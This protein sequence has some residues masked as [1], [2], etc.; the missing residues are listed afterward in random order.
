M[1]TG[2]T[3][4]IFELSFSSRY[5]P[6]ELFFPNLCCLFGLFSALSSCLN[7]FNYTKNPSIRSSS[8]VKSTGDIEKK[9]T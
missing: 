9:I 6:A 1:S 4:D 3:R 5:T 7:Y 8:L 2:Q